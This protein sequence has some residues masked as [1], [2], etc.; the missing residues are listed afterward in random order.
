VID[1]AGN[2]YVS[3]TTNNAIRK[4]TPAGDVTTLAGL[5]GVSGAQDGNGA[6]AFFNHPGG[7]AIDSAGN[8]YV[9]DTGNSVI[10]KI[11]A[12]GNVTTLAGLAGIA[13]LLDS[14]S[15]DAYFN[16]PQALSVDAGGN[17]YVADTG[18]ATIR[19]ITAANTVTTLTLSA[20]AAP[21]PTPTPAPTPSP[22]PS[23]GGGGGGGAIA[24]WF[25]AVLAGLRLAYRSKKRAVL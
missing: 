8:V 18:N 5:S 13:G 23:S 12:S 9:A 11:T 4:I 7:L 6:A 22:M 20:A 1:G 16:Q 17:L 14:A 24:S 15:A 2:L 3:D 21:T 25:V 10:R 19:K